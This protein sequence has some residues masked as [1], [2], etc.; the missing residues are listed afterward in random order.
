M[1]QHLLLEDFLSVPE[2]S[3]SVETSSRSTVPDVVEGNLARWLL[4]SWVSERVVE[5]YLSILDDKS[6]VDTW[7]QHLQ[8]LVVLHVVA[9]VFENI[10]VR[11]DTEGPED[12]PDWD[13]D[14]D[15]RDS[16][17]HDISQLHGA[18][19][20]LRTDMRCLP[21]YRAFLVSVVQLDLELTDRLSALF[22][23][24]TN[25]GKEADGRGLC[26]R[27]DVDMVGGHTF[28]GD[29]HF[30]GTVDDEI[31]SLFIRG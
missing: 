8:H 6:L 25:L 17:L 16:R 30:F 10:S 5:T 2:T 12:D 28:L 31:A 27:E 14:L 24:T 11:D 22:N 26:L 15:V 7:L 1:R 18:S 9:N 19:M 4:T 13:V 20:S 23:G 3:L 29:E 21:T